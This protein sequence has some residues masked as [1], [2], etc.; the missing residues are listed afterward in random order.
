ME[1]FSYRMRTW[2]DTAFHEVSIVKEPIGTSIELLQQNGGVSCSDIVREVSL[3]NRDVIH[4]IC[5]LM[6]ASN[7]RFPPALYKVIDII[8]RSNVEGVVIE[9]LAALKGG[10][11]GEWETVRRLLGVAEAGINIYVRSYALSE[12]ASSGNQRCVSRLC[13][14]LSNK[15]QNEL[16]RGAAAEALASFRIFTAVAALRSALSDDSA[17]VRFWACYS[18]GQLQDEGSLSE[19]QWHAE[20]D[21]GVSKQWGPVHIEAARAIKYILQGFVADDPNEG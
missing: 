13:K 19:L 12:L 15:K 9:G 21:L 6:G 14:L 5:V 10:Y 17:E 1:N 7:R 16:I 3:G 2:L 4:A 20:N 18:L 8:L 11:R